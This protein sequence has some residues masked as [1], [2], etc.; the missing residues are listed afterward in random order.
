MVMEYATRLSRSSKVKLTPLGKDEHDSQE[1]DGTTTQEF[2]TYLN[3]NG[4][5]R[6]FEIANYYNMSDG[7][8]V[9]IANALLR[10]KFIDLAQEEAVSNP[11]EEAVEEDTIDDLE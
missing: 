9:S 4:T 3:D 8:A 10:K 1:L 5:S 11:I 6:V 7:T 2:L